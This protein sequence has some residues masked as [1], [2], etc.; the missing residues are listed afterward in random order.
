MQICIPLRD[1]LVIEH[2]PPEWHHCDLYL[3]RD[4]RVVF[5]VGQSG[6]AFERVWDHLRSGYKGRSLV[7]RFVV[8]NWPRSMKFTVELLDSNA[9]QFADLGHD[10]DAAERHLIE[11]LSPC[12]N[13]ALNIQ[14]TPLPAEYL[15]PDATFRH[16]PGLKHIIRD[17]QRAIQ[18]EKN[19]RTWD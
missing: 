14:P 12:F 7:G 17:A 2:C 10:L 13:E 16:P 4:E 15:S 5:Y 9:A 6:C 18:R 11:R 19:L 8:F 3:F 1:F